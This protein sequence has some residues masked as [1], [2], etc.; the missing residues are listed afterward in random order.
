M[1]QI[2]DRY[3]EYEFDFATIT[4]TVTLDI[5]GTCTKVVSVKLES[6]EDALTYLRGAIME[7]VDEDEDYDARTLQEEEK[8]WAA[9]QDAEIIREDEC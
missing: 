9:S 8:E 6:D 3:F 1:A 5:S 7:R 4:G 2:V